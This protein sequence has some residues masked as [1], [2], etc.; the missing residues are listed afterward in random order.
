M[1]LGSRLGHPHADSGLIVLQDSPVAPAIREPVAPAAI[2]PAALPPA[3]RHNDAAAA[4]AA[5]AR[6]TI[7][8]YR[9]LPVRSVTAWHQFNVICEHL[10]LAR[11][12]ERLELEREAYC[13]ENGKIAGSSD[14]VRCHPN[15]CS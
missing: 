3:T 15:K 8:M 12:N 4:D 9:W 14:F 10:F 1:P 5:E 11:S 6:L 7:S 13:P 2:V